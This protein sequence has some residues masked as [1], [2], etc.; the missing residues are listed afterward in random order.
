MLTARAIDSIRE[1]VEAELGPRST[2]LAAALNACDSEY[3][4]AGQFHSSMRVARRGLIACQELTIRAEIIYGLIQRCRPWFSDLDD[5]LIADLGDQIR[6]HVTAQAAVVLQQSGLK[7]PSETSRYTKLVDEPLTECRDK[8]IRKFAIQARFFV[9]DL[10]RQPAAAV[11]GVTIH[12]NVG[13]LQT[14]A[15]ATARV[16]IDAAGSARLID[17]LEQ[18]RA[19]L[20]SAADMELG[21]REQGTEL[22]GDV[23]VAA[24]AG[25]PNGAKL[26]G[27]LMGLGTIVQTVASVRPAWEAVRQAANVIG[28]SLP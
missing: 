14:G 8:L 11:G 28:I 19:A 2:S 7:P 26:A 4:R 23:I 9:E 17:A 15:Y 10:R 25:K 22:V 12:G 21:E 3:A 5:V 13:A 16:H 27:L 6:E 18:L 1:S 20:P 24:R